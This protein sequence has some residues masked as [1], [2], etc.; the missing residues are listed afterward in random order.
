MYC[1]WCHTQWVYEYVWFI[2]ICK[3]TNVVSN[4]NDNAEMGNIVIATITLTFVYEL[5]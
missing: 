1:K 2:S 5:L 3:M 4:N